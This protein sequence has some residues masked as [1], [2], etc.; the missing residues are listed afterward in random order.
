MLQVASL[1]STRDSNEAE[2]LP[3][4]PSDEPPPLPP[5]D[6]PE[7]SNAHEQG[8]YWDYSADSAEYWQH[9][10]QH[11]GATQE[12]NHWNGDG[13]QY[14]SRQSTLHHAAAGE[15]KILSNI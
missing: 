14:S 1:P 3:P 7:G 2:T 5:S 4:L 6:E 13:T 15:Q 10:Y 8:R 12:Y 11:D 9:G